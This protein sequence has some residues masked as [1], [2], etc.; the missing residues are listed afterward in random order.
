MTRPIGELL[1]EGPGDSEEDTDGRWI[2]AVV[3]E[4]GADDELGVCLNV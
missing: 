1:E 2:G 4:D 3:M